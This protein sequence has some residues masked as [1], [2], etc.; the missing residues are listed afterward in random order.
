MEAL[1]P[2][3]ARQAGEGSDAV[4]PEFPGPWNLLREDCCTW[5]DPPLLDRQLYSDLRG[6][7]GNNV[8]REILLAA[9]GVKLSRTCLPDSKLELLRGI[10]GRRGFEVTASSE[11]YLHRPDLGKGGASN[12]IER[13][14]GPEEEGGLRNVYIAADPSLAKAG[15]ML[16]QASDDENFGLL[17]GIPSCC[18]EAY[19]Q[20]SSIASARQN[21]FVVLALDNTSG[22]MPYDFWVNYP[23]NYFGPDS[24]PRNRKASVPL[25][26]SS[27]STTKSFCRAKRD[28]TSLHVRLTATRGIG[29]NP[30]FW[31]FLPPVR[32]SL[33]PWQGW[34]RRNIHISQ[35]AFFF[36][37]GQALNGVGG[38][39]LP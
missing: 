19:M 25:V 13:L 21:D 7:F 26:L 11:R 16:E 12:T 39:T 15:E 35:A 32:A 20:G 30:K 5:R 33:Q 38:A 2:E 29:S 27:A 24:S 10:A 14:A 31:S 6:H 18:R 23:A 34:V 9:A 1:L 22:T 8:I 28:R 17:L 37:T 36:R 3:S 4:T